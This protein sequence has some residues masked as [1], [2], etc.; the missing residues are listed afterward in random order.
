MFRDSVV[1]HL[2]DD[3]AHTGHAVSRDDGV[4]NVVP[5][6]ERCLQL[7]HDGGDPATQSL[8]RE[9][10]RRQVVVGDPVVR[11]GRQID[12]DQ[13]VVKRSIVCDAAAQQ[14]VQGMGVRVDEAGQR[15]ASRCVD[16]LVGVA[17]A[18]AHRSDGVDDGAA[19]RDEALV[20]DPSRGVHRHHPGIADEQ[21]VRHRHP[22][23]SH[24]ARCAKPR[25]RGRT[26]ARQ[27]RRSPR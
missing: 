26:R 18:F 14:D 15:S 9:E 7:V 21:C 20:D 2:A 12:V 16:H 1:E 22:V 11:T 6:V 13:P 17:R 5:R 8:G 25:P 27:G 10:A 23:H 19:D 3:R 24:S 4:G